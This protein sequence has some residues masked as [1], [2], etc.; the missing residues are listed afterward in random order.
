MLTDADN[1]SFQK[2]LLS[3]AKGLGKGQPRKVKKQNLSGE[4]LSAISLSSGTEK[5]VCSCTVF[6]IATLE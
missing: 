3:I 4:T 2:M 5:D 1:K 6:N